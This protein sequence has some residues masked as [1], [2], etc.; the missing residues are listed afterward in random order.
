VFKQ[1]TVA[2]GALTLANAANLYL[3]CLSSDAT[4]LINNF[5]SVASQYEAVGYKCTTVNIS[6]I[7][8]VNLGVSNCTIESTIETVVD[9]VVSELNQLLAKAG[10]ADLTNILSNVVGDVE[11]LLT[12]AGCIALPFGL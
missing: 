6:V 4:S 2:A 5:N 9:D 11:N 7:G 10:V 8:K 1:I 3:G 12:N